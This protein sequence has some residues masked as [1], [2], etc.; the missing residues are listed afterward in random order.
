MSTQPCIAGKRRMQMSAPAA[1]VAGDA[2]SGPTVPAYGALAGSWAVAAGAAA[3]LALASVAEAL[4][5]GEDEAA[6]SPARFTVYEPAGQ[7]HVRLDASGRYQVQVRGLRPL[8]PTVL[9]Q[10]GG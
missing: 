1:G 10:A 5:P 6:L 8:S 7:Y 3:L 4:L 9:A 2:H